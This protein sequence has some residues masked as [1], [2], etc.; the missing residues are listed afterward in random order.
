M[1]QY[2]W[3]WRWGDGGDNIE[4]LSLLS[5]SWR[6]LL[7]IF[8]IW[9]NP[10]KWMAP[11]PAPKTHAFKWY[12]HGRICAVL[13]CQGGEAN[14]RPNIALLPRFCP[15]SSRF[16]P[17]IQLGVKYAYGI[18][19]MIFSLPW[20]LKPEQ[21]TA[22][23]RGQPR[24][25]ASV[26]IPP[27]QIPQSRRRGPRPVAAPSTALAVSKQWRPVTVS[28]WW[29]WRPVSHCVTRHNIPR[30]WI[31]SSLCVMDDLVS[32]VSKWR[33]CCNV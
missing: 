7:A 23:D 1:D 2:N 9:M 11:N 12:I 29:R 21:S 24:E 32:A 27:L 16:S 18:N 19:L 8:T 13:L 5:P 28:W 4:P 25:S 17:Q 10:R 30:V 15:F 20:W 6:M 3:Q 26:T 31:V 22:M 33:W 14:V